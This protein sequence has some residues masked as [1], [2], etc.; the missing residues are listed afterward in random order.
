MISIA[1]PSIGKEESMAVMR[2]LESGAL[3]S[4]KVV[5]EFEAALAARLGFRHAVAVSSGTAGL[6]IALA[7]LG[8]KAGDEVAV[9]DFSFIATASSCVFAGATPVFCGVDWKTFNISPD[10]LGNAF[11]ASTRAVMPVSLYG[12][13][14]DVGQVLGLA[15]EKGVPVISDNC[16]AVGAEHCGKTNF[17][18]DASVLS[19][20]PTKN[21]T[22]GEGG[23]VLTD[24]DDVAEKARLLRSHGMKSRYEY[25]MLG[26]NYRM[27]NIAA[28]IGLEQLKKLDSF[29]AARRRNAAMLDD[30]L[31]G[32]RGLELPFEPPNFKHVYHQYTVKAERRDQLQKFLE[33]KGIASVVYYPRPLHE[34]SVLPGRDVGCY[35]TLQLAKS[36][37]SLPVHPALSEGEVHEVADAVRAFYA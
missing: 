6:H 20:Y 17:G 19:F 4:G 5:E 26:Y 13:P 34:I 7:A 33:E 16:Q 21:I 23:A 35:G 32:V 10:S 22:T 31:S 8:V 24:R 1:K 37:L 2:V 28:A 36:V 3:A 18:E 9:P 29:N 30:L 25:A 12:L 15:R 14:Y 11:S 27:T